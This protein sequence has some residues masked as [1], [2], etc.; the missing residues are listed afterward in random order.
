MLEEGNMIQKIGQINAIRSE[1]YFYRH[2]GLFKLCG[3]VNVILDC[4]R[5]CQSCHKQ[6][7]HLI[8]HS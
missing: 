2:L 5:R 1:K 3:R 7:M 6:G 4:H 8:K